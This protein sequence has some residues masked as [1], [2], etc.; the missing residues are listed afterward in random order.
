MLLIQGHGEVGAR[1]GKLPFCDLAGGAI[2]YRNLA[3]R[4]EIRKDERPP[5][6]QLKR[7]GMR[8]EFEVLPYTLIGHRIEGADSSISV[9]HIHALTGGIV[10]QLVGV[11]GKL[12]SANG[13]VSITIK[14][15]AGATAA[16]GDHDAVALQD[17]SHPLRLIQSAADGMNAP[18]AADVHDLH[19]V[20][21]ENRGKN[22]A[23]LRVN[24]H[25]VKSALGAGQGNNA[26]QDQWLRFFVGRNLLS[27]KPGAQSQESKD[28]QRPKARLVAGQVERRNVAAKYALH[29]SHF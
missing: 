13:P 27:G 12:D 14:N 21:T 6:L 3:D 22:P 26:H 19:R 1:L 23:T 2:D 9:S 29:S 17:V 28:E 18:G 24:G 20:V 15:L 11:V 4:S 8:A 5:L 16:V 7:L 10:A 25:V